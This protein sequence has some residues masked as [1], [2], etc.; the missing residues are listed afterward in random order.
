[1]VVWTMSGIL[2]SKM[3]SKNFMVLGNKR[4][5]RQFK[6]S[7][8]GMVMFSRRRNVVVTSLITWLKNA[9][10]HSVESLHF[11]FQ[12]LDATLSGPVVFPDFNRLIAYLTHV[13]VPDGIGP[14]ISSTDGS[15]WKWR[16]K[17]NYLSWTCL[18]GRS[19]ANVTW[20]SSAGIRQRL[21]ELS[22]TLRNL[23]SEQKSS[24]HQADSGSTTKTENSFWIQRKG[25]VEVKTEE[26]W[27]GHRFQ[28]QR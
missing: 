14:N 13:V 6:H 25:H 10:I 9:L 4:I 19:E 18:W 16:R 15:P 5:R 22:A 21:N 17:V 8:I 26:R 12:S 2:V 11:A 23:F 24:H 3:H 7:T 20:R 1:M 27:F 28:R